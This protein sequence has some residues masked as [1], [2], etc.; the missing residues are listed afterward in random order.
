MAVKNQFSVKK[1]LPLFFATY[2][3]LTLLFTL[4]P[5]PILLSTDP[6][7]IELFFNDTHGAFL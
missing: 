3:C 5:R 6:S 7:E 1:V 4:Y 2:I